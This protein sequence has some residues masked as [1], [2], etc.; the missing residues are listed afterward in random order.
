[1]SVFCVSLDLIL[2]LSIIS[3]ILV[4]VSLWFVTIDD[5]IVSNLLT[6]LR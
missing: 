3:V 6:V 4:S 1:M 2:R 5:N